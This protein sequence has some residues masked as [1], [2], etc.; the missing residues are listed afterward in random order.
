M[1]YLYVTL[2]LS[3]FTCIS[4]NGFAQSQAD[5]VKAIENRARAAF[6]QKLDSAKAEQ[7]KMN[8]LIMMESRRQKLILNLVVLAFL[9]LLAY[10]FVLLRK[11]GK[12]KSELEES[13]N[14]LPPKSS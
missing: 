11:I 3:F 12:L 9:L 8:T 1:K 2:I 13:R 14:S 4:L 6:E 10:V 7:D 5:S